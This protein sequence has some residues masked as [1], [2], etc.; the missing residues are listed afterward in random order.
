MKKVLAFL[1]TLTMVFAV[2]ACSPAGGGAGGAK[3]YAIIVK[4][5]GNPYNDK[6]AAGFEEA[7]KEIGVECIIK[8]P[9]NPTAEDQIAMIQELI[10]QKVSG[11]AIAANDYDALENALKKAKDAGIAVATVDSNA[12]PNSR[13][14]FA[15]Q[16]DTVQIGK[17]LV[18]TAFDLTGG[19]GQFAI[20][21]ATAQA[22]NQNAWIAEMEKALTDP[23]YADLELVKIAYGDD[24]RDKSVS[25]TEGLIQSFPD[26]KCIIAPTT[27]GIA[28]ASKVVIDQGLS[29]K[30]KVSG[31]GLPSEMAEY[32]EQGVCPYMYLW[33]PIDLGYLT[34]YI[35]DALANKTIT[36][37]EGDAFKAGRLGDYKVTAAAD[38]G[39][40]VLL[41]PPFAFTPDNIGE[42]KTV[43]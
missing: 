28:A 35:V 20:L 12:N 9:A 10:S 21:S 6:E 39:T 37:A 24:L 41:G 40:E 5:T 4:S 1:L 42:W 25:E 33:N 30:I 36:G 7:C 18:E 19:S 26:L 17:T 31:L 14:T 38:G 23:K 29:D 2:A 34:G 43:Y 13:Q 15:N 22:A 32:I 11:I 16:A 8:A 3:K 27:V